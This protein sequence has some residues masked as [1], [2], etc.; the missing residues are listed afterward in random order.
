MNVRL[1]S[2]RAA[3][4]LAVFGALALAGCGGGGSSKSMLPLPANGATAPA[5]N[6]PTMLTA[7]GQSVPAGTLTVTLP[8]HTSSQVQST[9]R[10]A[11]FS[12]AKKPTFI[13]TTTQTSSLVVSVAP[14]DPSEASQFGNLT[15]C[16]NLY[17]NGALAP[18]ATGFATSNL[19]PTAGGAGAGLETVTI[20]VPAPPGTDGFQITQY[21]GGCGST[22]FTLPTPPPGNLGTSNI[23]AQ[24]P[25]TLAYMAPGAPNNLNQ[26]I[27]NCAVPL[28]PTQC[29]LTTTPNAGTVFAASVSVASVVFGTVPITNPVREQGAFLMANGRIGVPIPLEA[30]DAAGAVIPGLTTFAVPAGGAGPFP[31]GVTVTDGDTSGHTKLYLI[32]AANGGIAQGPATS[33]TI[34][35]FNALSDNTT[36]G[37][38]SVCGAGAAS[39]NDNTAGGGANGDP[40]I[41]V[42]TSDGV[43]ASL[44]S[45]TT[46]TATATV[47][48]AALPAA[49]TTTISPQSSVYSAGGTGYVDTAAPAAPL[50]L[51]QPIA[52]GAVYFTDG[53]QV[54]VDGANTPSATTGTTLTGLSYAPVTTPMLYA[55]DNAAAGGTTAPSGLYAFNPAAALAVTPV[56]TSDGNG[57]EVT[58]KTPVASVFANDLGTGSPKLFVIDANG[59]EEVDIT[60]ATQ[61]ATNVGPLVCSGTPLAAP[62]AGVKLLGTVAVNSASTSFLVADPGNAR[63]AAIAVNQFNCTITTY[64]SGAAFTGLA[65]LAAGALYATSTTGQVYYISGSGATGA[66]LGLT[67]AAAASTKDGPIGQLSALGATPTGTLAPVS[68]KTQFQAGSFFDTVGPTTGLAAPYNLAPFNGTKAVAA[69]PAPL[70]G[71]PDTS[72]A[73]AASVGLVNATGGIILV[74]TTAGVGATVTPDSL[75]FVDSAGT[76]SA[77]LRTL[78]R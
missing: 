73:Q 58:F 10:A 29:P 56:T 74:P 22:V 19:P 59:I 41:I 64:A 21:A 8:S 44:L 47:A 67:T 72:S 20:A 26:Q 13:D 33:I 78:V 35:E 60:Q 55:V 38:I 40:W 27:F 2:L 49:I 50:A 54:K 43:D 6:V 7:G 28:S 77:K 51:I 9:A 5:N 3:A 66:S 68:Y 17:V 57:H 31:S 16:Y 42:L 30:K 1:T 52:A 65:P 61:N 25:V 12:V 46:V 45:T 69:V 76:A 62:P 23:L 32:D 11:I 18:N 15:I 71:F 37:L 48:N 63:V 75:L 4:V 53:N 39:C 34:H 36:P 14:Q 70:V 24:T